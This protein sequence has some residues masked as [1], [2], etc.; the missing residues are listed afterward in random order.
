[1]NVARFFETSVIIY[2]TGRRHTPE[3]STL[4]SYLCENLKSKIIYLLLSSAL[5]AY[6]PYF[7]N[8]KVG[9]RDHLAV[10]VCVCLSERESPSNNV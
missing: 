2:Q 8:I 10:C 3:Y 4:H 9:L 1:M 7:E 5:L 6:F